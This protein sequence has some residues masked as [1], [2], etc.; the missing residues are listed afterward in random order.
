M[1]RDHVTE[2]RRRQFGLV[3]EHGRVAD[4]KLQHP[5][6][7]RNRPRHQRVEIADIGRQQIPAEPK[8]D[9]LCR[10]VPGEGGFGAIG[11][12][13]GFAFVDHGNAAV[14]V[15]FARSALHH[16]KDDI[17]IVDKGRRVAVVHGRQGSRGHGE[18]RDRPQR[19][20]DIE[21]MAFERIDFDT[22]NLAAENFA[23]GLYATIFLKG[24]G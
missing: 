5:I 19:Q 17:V 4:Q 10:G 1:R 7:F 21:R 6:V 22:E 12:E 2:F 3:V 14:L 18:A 16:D 11:G 13:N 20:I 23:K 8:I 24:F 15:Y 9:H